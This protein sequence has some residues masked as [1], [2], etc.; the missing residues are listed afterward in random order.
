MFPVRTWLYWEL[1]CTCQ[2]STLSVFC[3]AW[4]NTLNSHPAKTHHIKSSAYERSCTCG[5]RFGLSIRMHFV[6][7]SALNEAT[8]ATVSRTAETRAARWRYRATGMNHAAVG[9][10]GVGGL[11]PVPTSIAFSAHVE[12]RVRVIIIIYFFLQ[13]LD[14]H[15]SFQ[16]T[17]DEEDPYVVSD[18]CCSESVILI[19][20]R[21]FVASGGTDPADGWCFHATTV[22]TPLVFPLIFCRRH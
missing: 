9:I 19:L 12:T 3:N 22:L 6:G 14:Q 1:N 21:C 7:L 10:E 5:S 13:T 8:A 11:G 20:Q 18:C 15:L 2:T 17:A 4:S 16:R